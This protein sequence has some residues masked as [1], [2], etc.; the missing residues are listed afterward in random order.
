M[1]KI[2]IVNS[3]Y[4]KDVSKNLEKSS[5]EILRRNKILTIIINV[6]GIFKIY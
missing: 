6:P 5:F 2:L 1:K 4:Y 3:N